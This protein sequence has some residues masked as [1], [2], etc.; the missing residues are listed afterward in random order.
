MLV[1][2]VPLGTQVR[3]PPPR[4]PTQTRSHSHVHAD[5]ETRADAIRRGS[6][7]LRPKATPSPAEKPSGPPLPS[8]SLSSF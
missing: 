6:L 1:I 8:F 2:I 7:S 3:S 5:A 4:A